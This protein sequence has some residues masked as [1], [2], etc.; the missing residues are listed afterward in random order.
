MAIPTWTAVAATGGGDK[1]S[2]NQVRPPAGEI[3]SLTLIFAGVS[4][5][6]SDTAAATV[7]GVDEVSSVSV[8]TAGVAEGFERVKEPPCRQHW[9]PGAVTWVSVAVIVEAES[10][11]SLDTDNAGNGNT[12]SLNVIAQEYTPGDDPTVLVT[13]VWPYP[14]CSKALMMSYMEAFHGMLTALDVP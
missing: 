12:A 10:K 2:I 9:A 7:D 14:S 8:V 3:I 13:A 4:P 1:N 11:P 6:R 5:V